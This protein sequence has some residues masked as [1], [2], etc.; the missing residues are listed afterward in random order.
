MTRSSLSTGQF[1]CVRCRSLISTVAIY[2]RVSWSTCPSSCLQV[3]S[4]VCYRKR[5]SQ[6]ASKGKDEQI[7]LLFKE[8]PFYKTSTFHEAC[9][10]LKN[11]GKILCFIGKWGSGKSA[12]AEQ[13]YTS[14]T[15]REPVVI[16]DI[17]NFE[18]STCQESVIVEEPLPS[19]D[20][21]DVERS[22]ILKRLI[23]LCKRTQET[24]KNKTFLI[25]TFT[26][27]AWKNIAK[28]MHNC[29]FTIN[30]L[31]SFGLNWKDISNGERIQILHTIFQAYKRDTPFSTVE[32]VVLRFKN[33]Y[34]EF[35]EICTLFLD[36]ANFRHM[37][38]YSLIDR[39]VI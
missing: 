25:I 7:P 9:E 24:Y 32:K 28:E 35:P 36:V 18:V 8:T 39:Y 23:T 14:F 3:V 16:K 15:E 19:E 2:R 5:R 38:L 21:P 10:F 17:L 29:S 31:R 20:V 30:K 27:E 34:V 11:D 6:E 33:L 26:D 12:T 1:C 13:V 22:D 4:F 37:I